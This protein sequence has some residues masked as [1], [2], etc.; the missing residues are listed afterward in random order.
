MLATMVYDAHR[1]STS[2]ME[3]LIRLFTLPI[4]LSR[5]TR[6]IH[7]ITNSGISWMLVFCIQ[8]ILNGIRSV[9][10]IGDNQNAIYMHHNHSCLYSRIGKI[11]WYKPIMFN[12]HNKLN[13]IELHLFTC[14]SGLRASMRFL[15]CNGKNQQD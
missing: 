9:C 5:A 4:D 14:L 12:L 1:K 6:V 15:E 8:R 11:K 7:K 13:Y 3:T 10:N 2:T